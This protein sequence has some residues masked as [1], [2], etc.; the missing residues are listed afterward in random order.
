MSPWQQHSR[1]L[2][3]QLTYQFVLLTEL[4]PVLSTEISRVLE[5]MEKET[6][7]SKTVF[8]HIQ[9]RHKYFFTLLSVAAKFKGIH[10]FILMRSQE[11]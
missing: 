10:A 2:T 4:L 8:S 5:K 9:L 6:Q 11:E 3:Y 7:V 1:Q